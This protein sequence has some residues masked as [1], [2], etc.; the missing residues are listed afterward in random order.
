MSGQHGKKYT[1]EKNLVLKE[2]S[3]QAPTQVSEKGTS[4][5]PFQRPLIN[6]TPASARCPK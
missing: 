1:G 4:T 2:H 3:N 5:P 6:M